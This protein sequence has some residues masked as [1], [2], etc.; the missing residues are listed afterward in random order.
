[1]RGLLGSLALAAFAASVGWGGASAQTVAGVVEQWGLL[2]TWAV[3][4]RQPPSGNRTHFTYVK[5]PDGAGVDARRDFG[6][7]AVNDSS[8]IRSARILPDGSLE[9]SEDSADPFT[10]VTIKGSDG[11]IRSMTGR[12]GNGQY[13][14]RDGRFVHNGAPTPWQTRCR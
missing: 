12:T 5:R 4:C 9:L 8:R 6:D 7:P 13:T 14:V 2:G 3:D 11:R 1:M 10:W